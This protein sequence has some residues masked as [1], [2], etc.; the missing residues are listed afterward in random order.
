MIHMSTLTI[1]QHNL[2]MS[3]SLGGVDI[4]KNQMV[5]Q[6]QFL[7]SLATTRPR[8]ASATHRPSSPAYAAIMAT[9]SKMTT[10]HIPNSTTWA[11]RTF[12]DL[13]LGVLLTVV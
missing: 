1:P 6:K 11:W 13:R 2:Q 4:Q 5:Q 9:R 7:E 10:I 8:A 12:I 3:R